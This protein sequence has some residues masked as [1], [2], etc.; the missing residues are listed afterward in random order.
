VGN[1]MRH[2]NTV[3]LG[4]LEKLLLATMDMAPQGLRHTYAKIDRLAR[5]SVPQK[6]ERRKKS[7]T[8]SQFIGDAVPKFGLVPGHPIRG[9]QFLGGASGRRAFRS[10]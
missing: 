10:W 7:S 3:A 6:K 9:L 8:N 1:E 2:L 5:H 4:F